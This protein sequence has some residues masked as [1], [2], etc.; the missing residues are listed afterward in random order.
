MVTDQ[1]GTKISCLTEN[2]ELSVVV[3]VHNESENIVPLVSE[4]KAALE[5]HLNYEVVYVDDGSNDGTLEKLRSMAKQFPRLR[6]VR[7][8]RR[9]GQS[10]AIWTGVKAARGKWIATLDGDG[11]NDPQDILF[12]I[13]AKGG[14]ERLSKEVIICGYR[15]KRRDTWIKRI[16]SKIANAVRS[17]MLMDDTPDTGCGLKVFAREA[18]LSLPF[19]DHMHRFLPALFLSKGGRIESFEVNHRPRSKGKTHYGIKN[20]LGVGIVDLFGVMWLRRRMK[21]PVATEEKIET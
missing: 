2:P 12:I 19:F 18:Y 13:S 3:P 10:A 15:K 21:N 4:I 14:L 16:S 11:Q 7:H 17:K 5:G 6:V 20:R 1:M 8:Y 9:C